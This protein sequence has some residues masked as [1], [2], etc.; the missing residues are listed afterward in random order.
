M[1]W[2]WKISFGRTLPDFIF[3]GIRLL[4]LHTQIRILRD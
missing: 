4:D 3:D 1:I 2:F